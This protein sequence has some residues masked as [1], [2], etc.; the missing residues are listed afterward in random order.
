MFKSISEREVKFTQFKRL[1]AQNTKKISKELKSKKQKPLKTYYAEVLYFPLYVNFR[2]RELFSQ[3]V[4]YFGSLFRA[5]H[6]KLM[7]SFFKAWPN[8]FNFL[9]FAIKLPPSQTCKKSPVNQKFV[10]VLSSQSL[11]TLNI[12]EDKEALM[13]F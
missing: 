12:A 6:L 1:L 8:L 3:R 7:L 9:T 2:N 11:H 10:N 13:Y 5:T 4:Y